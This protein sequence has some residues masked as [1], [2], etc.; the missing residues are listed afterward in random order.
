MQKQM[1]SRRCCWSPDVHL[2]DLGL[3]SER[4]VSE[5]GR[6]RDADGVQGRQDFRAAALLGLGGVLPRWGGLKRRDE[7]DML[8]F[9]ERFN[10]H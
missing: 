1:S 6:A 3:F 10:V 8:T 5:G 4:P 2:Q 7:Q 9:V